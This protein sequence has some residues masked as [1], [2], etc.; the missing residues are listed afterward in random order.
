MPLIKKITSPHND[1]GYRRPR[2][3]RHDFLCESTA[4]AFA[5]AQPSKFDRRT[6]GR[7]TLLGPIQRRCTYCANSKKLSFDRQLVAITKKYESIRI[8]RVSQ[9]RQC[10]IRGAP[11][12]PGCQADSMEIDVPLYSGEGASQLLLCR[13][14]Y[15]YRTGH[16]KVRHRNPRGWSAPMS[17][18]NRRRGNHS[19]MQIQSS[20]GSAGLGSLVVAG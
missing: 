9:M 7:D 6:E 4:E 1:F 13:Y 11:N 14:T 19:T 3:C 20:T 8:R 16:P 10:R 17:A 12:R 18:S 2:L 15:S 5:L